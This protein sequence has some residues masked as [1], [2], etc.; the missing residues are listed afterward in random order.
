MNIAF[1]DFDGTIT[2]KDT[3]SDFIQYALGS[4][5]YYW[6]LIRLSPMLIAYGCKLIPNHVAKEKLITYFFGGWSASAFHNMAHTYALK[7]IEKIVRPHA[8]EK[9]QWHTK[10]GDRVVIVSA[11]VDSWLIGWCDSYRFE[12]LATRLEITDNTLTGKF[13]GKNCYG[14]EKVRRI[15]ECYRLDDYDTVYAYGDT[16]GDKEMLALAHESFY[17]PFR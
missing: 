6:G 13:L 2:T 15:L 3:L 1:F 7:E 14:A 9:L 11:S 10:R 16:Q 12:L 4:P 17:K 5:A 8:K